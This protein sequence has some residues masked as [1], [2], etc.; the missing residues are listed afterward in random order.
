MGMLYWRIYWCVM[1]RKNQWNEEDGDKVG[2]V[3]EGSTNGMRKS[4]KS[5]GD[6]GEKIPMESLQIKIYW[7]I[8]R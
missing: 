5:L 1:G 4:E 7:E 6:L 3:C 2:V 8:H